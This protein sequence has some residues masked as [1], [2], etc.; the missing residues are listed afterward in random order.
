MF[1]NFDFLRSIYFLAGVTGSGPVPLR[2]DMKIAMAIEHFGIGRGGAESYAVELARRL[3]S[4]GWEVHLYGHSWDQDPEGAIFHPIDELPRWIPPSIRVLHF[5]LR[6]RALVK[7]LDFDVVLGFGNTLVMNVYQTHGG[8]HF[9]SNIRKLNAVHSPILRFMKRLVLVLTPKYHAR[10]WIEAAPFRMPEPPIVVAISDMVKRDIAEYFRI[11][12][13]QIRLV[14]N[15]IDLTRFGRNPDPGNRLTLRKR[16]GFDARVLFLFMAY[17]FRKKGVKYLIDAAGKLLSEV[18]PGKFGVVIVGRTP[19]VALKQQVTKL[20]LDKVVVFPGPTR[21]PEDYYQACDVFV[22]PTFYDACSLVIFEAMAQGLP[23]IT[24]IHNG[25]A[26]IITQR[27][28]GIV[29]ND[30]ADS[31]EMA[32]ALDHFLDPHVRASASESARRTAAGFTLEINHRQ[33]ISI[34]EEAARGR[35]E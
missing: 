11:D 12:S 21:H 3:V 35:R 27:V 6:H 23:A 20:G 31:A 10:A 22:L 18:G 24:T 25:A 28:D 19:P 26:G 16:L 1:N 4:L 32:R 15:G 5:A 2:G 9:L 13:S 17:D 14:Y 30:P 29:L 34:I 33:M 8:V 7:E